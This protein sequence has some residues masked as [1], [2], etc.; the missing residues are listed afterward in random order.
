MNKLLGL[1]LAGGKGERLKHLTQTMP[2][3]LVPYAGTCRMIDYSLNNCVASGLDEILLLSR[4]EERKIHDYLLSS[5]CSRINLHF[6]CYQALHH[7]PP[8]KVYAGIK[9]KEEKGTADALIQNRQ[10]IDRDEFDDLL[11]LHSD[12]I[13][14]FDYRQMYAQHRQNKAALTIGY[15][16]IPRK[17]VHL[18]GM[19]SF[20]KDQ[21]LTSFVEKPQDPSSDTIFTAVCIFNKRKMF[22]Y[23]DELQNTNWQFDISHDLIPAMLENDEKIKCFPFKGYWEDIGTTERYYQ[24]HLR[25]IH[26]DHTLASPQTIAG[27]ETLEIFNSANFKQVIMPEALQHTDFTARNSLI[28]PGVKIDAGCHIENSVL[29]PNFKAFAHMN[30]HNALANEHGVEIFPGEAR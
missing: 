27:C 29:L 22:E 19:V 9:R 26:K 7:Q 14:N 28:Y 2:K 24:G 17:Y 16:Q 3:P 8:E 13:Y 20:D 6:G 15:Q 23:L 12:H 18:F 30:L 5:W 21:N 11:I 10:F 25:L 1:L 4:H